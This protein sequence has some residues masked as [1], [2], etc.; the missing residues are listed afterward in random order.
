MSHYLRIL[1]STL[2]IEGVYSNDPDDPG[3][4][5]YCGIAR[6]RH[7]TWTGWKIVDHHK[8]RQGG[9]FRGF[10]F[11]E[12]LARDSDLRWEVEEFY[13]VK[14]W[15]RIEGDKV[16]LISSLIAEELFDTAVNLYITR[17]VKFLQRALSLLNKEEELYP[18]LVVDGLIGPA[19]LNALW[20]FVDKYGTEDL[21]VLMNVLQGARY[22]EL[23]ERNPKLEKYLRGWIRKRV[24][25]R[26][27]EVKE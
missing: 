2:R 12:A 26:K 1:K 14:F 10:P 18:D 24:L 5:T 8:A 17:A 23:V 7:S 13:R 6:K 27:K 19:T 11:V 3:G 16:A 9:K 4:E 20:K 25:L 22:V 15:D 21:L